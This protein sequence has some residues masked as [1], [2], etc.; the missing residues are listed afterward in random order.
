MPEA[1]LAEL[2]RKLEDAGGP[3]QS[4]EGAET[5][6]EAGYRVVRMTCRF[7]H[8]RKVLSVV[9]REDAIAGR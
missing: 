5:T 4:V 1:S 3:L 7:A 9:L 6:E 2:W 8:L